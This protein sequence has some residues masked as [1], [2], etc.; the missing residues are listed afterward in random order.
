MAISFIGG[1]NRS[2]QRK[3]LGVWCL[4][5]LLKVALNII[6]YTPSSLI[7]SSL[8]WQSNFQ[9]ICCTLIR[10]LFQEQM[11]IQ[12]KHFTLRSILLMK[13][14][15]VIVPFYIYMYILTINGSILLGG[16]HLHK[17]CK[18]KSEIN[19]LFLVAPITNCLSLTTMS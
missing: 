14:N 3:P 18:A 2:T 19:L 1:G 6:T 8:L 16:Q 11:Y 15:V 10:R 5:I 12:E 9:C 7:S 13:N 4:T 17:L